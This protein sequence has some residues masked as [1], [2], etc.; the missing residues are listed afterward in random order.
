MPKL[1]SMR[2]RLACYFCLLA[3][4][5]AFTGCTMNPLPNDPVYRGP[6]FAPKNY[7]GEKT[8]P[9]D[10]RRVVVL[11]VYGGGLAEA[12]SLA[13][14]DAAL[15]A[16]LQKQSRFEVVPL[17]RSECLRRFGVTELLSTAVLPNDFLET[18]ARAYAADAVLFTDITA[19]QAYRPLSLGLRAKLATLRDA[20]MVWNFDEVFSTTDPAVAN[21]ARRFYLQSESNSFP[22]D[23]TQSVLQSPSRFAAYVTATMFAT[24]PPR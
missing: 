10:V 13:S 20:R 23:M 6:F 8:M 14:L 12:E 7:A 17:T 21:S 18:L 3:I 4:A 22:V 5:V 19:Y 1:I 9:A 24:L 11:P 16:A 15:L 2:A